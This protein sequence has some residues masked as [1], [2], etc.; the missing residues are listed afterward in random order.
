MGTTLIC[1]SLSAG[2]CCEI[3]PGVKTWKHLWEQSPDEHEV[4]TWFAKSTDG[5]RSVFSEIIGKGVLQVEW[6]NGCSCYVRVCSTDS[7]LRGPEK[8][9]C[10]C[11]ARVPPVWPG[12][13]ARWTIIFKLNANQLQ[14]VGARSMQDSPHLA[15]SMIWGILLNPV[16]TMHAMLNNNSVSS[17]VI[18]SSLFTFTFLHFYFFFFFSLDLYS[19]PSL[20][21]HV[22]H[23]A[24]IFV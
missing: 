5:V 10:S 2:N 13:S 17:P 22:S 15:S 16:S 21:T 14:N 1:R 7:V 11:Y 3:V 8:V 19:I 12:I 4:Q 6:N 24:L 18:L 23:F 20:T 9:L